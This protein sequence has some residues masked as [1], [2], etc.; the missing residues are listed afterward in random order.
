MKL[1]DEMEALL[2]ELVGD[3]IGRDCECPSCEE[4]REKM[5]EAIR[6]EIALAHVESGA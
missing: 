1:S 6:K 2:L 5:R 3:N 4:D